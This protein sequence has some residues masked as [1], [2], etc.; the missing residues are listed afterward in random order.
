MALEG[1]QLFL[2]KRIVAEKDILDGGILVNESGIIEKIVNRT[3]ADKI[4][5]DND[6]KIKVVDGGDLALLAGVV[7]SH[8]HVNEP[9]RTAWEGFRTATNAA[10]AGGITT[11]V[12]MPLNSIPPT[13]TLKN[14]KTK[15]SSAKGN[16]FVDV[17]FW[18]GVIP[19][20][21]DSLR[22]L[23]KAGVV[24]F[25]CFLCP[26][27]VD[28]FP[29]VEP[30]DLEKAFEAL[31]GTGSLLAFHAEVEE[32]T[33]ASKK[34]IKKKD[35]EEYETYLESRPSSM[36]QNAISLVTSFL[37]STNVRVHIVHV[38]SA[39]VVPMLVKARNDRIAAGHSGWRGGVTAE[40][41]HHYLTLCADDVPRGRSEYKCAPPIRDKDNKEKL[42]QYLLEDKLDLVVSDH[43]PC[44]PEL[45]CTNNLEAWGGISSVQFG[46]S[47]FWTNAVG[48]GLD[49]QTV[50]KYLSSGPAHLCGIQDRKGVLKE[51]LDAD[52]VFFDPDASFVVT[53]DIIRHKNKLTPYI[54]KELKGVVKKTY[55]RG[56]LIYADGDIV[57]EPKGT[58]LLNNF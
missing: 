39:S 23:V 33:A 18:G 58:L 46:L 14:L 29:N 12:D 43:S 27:G 26:S 40:T 49:L 44:T 6:G 2:S 31:E 7:D 41:C 9:G 24:G 5:A 4:I 45:K 10:A 13:T 32:E 51:G 19:G 37:D 34:K 22:D 47:L 38:S 28:E 42:W 16:I 3:E 53:S 54:G 8:V 48:R 20:N 36:E 15:A 35:P 52:L 25:K 30:K 57:G 55:L 11:I 21:Q 1:Q 56:Q 17:G 50:S